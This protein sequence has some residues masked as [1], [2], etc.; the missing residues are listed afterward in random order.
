LRR[1]AEDLYFAACLTVTFVYSTTKELVQGSFT[2]LR[3][4][5]DESIRAVLGLARG[6]PAVAAQSPAAR[7]EGAAIRPGEDSNVQRRG[8]MM[9]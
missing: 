2:T 5:M 3:R 8:A 7:L 4:E 9:A 6:P 1:G